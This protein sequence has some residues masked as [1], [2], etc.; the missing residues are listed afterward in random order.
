MSEFD[1]CQAAREHILLTAHR[2]VA[3]GNI[4]CNSMECYRIALTQDADII[5]MDV[6]ACKDKEEL[7]MLHP[8]MEP[9]HTTAPSALHNFTKKEVERILKQMAW[10]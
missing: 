1:L 2:G 4:P 7:F 3:G 8:G 10:W 9:V 6:T 5:E